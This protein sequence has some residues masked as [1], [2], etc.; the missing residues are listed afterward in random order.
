MS[1]SEERKEPG[2]INTVKTTEKER[3]EWNNEYESMKSSYG[4]YK[5]KTP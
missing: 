2:E 5:V 3:N 1:K 4:I